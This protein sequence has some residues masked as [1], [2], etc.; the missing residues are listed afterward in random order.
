[1][2]K[3]YSIF[4]LMCSLCVAG[5]ASEAKQVASGLVKGSEPE[6]FGIPTV[7][8]ESANPA[9]TSSNY[10]RA[11]RTAPYVCYGAFVLLSIPVSGVTSNNLSAFTENNCG[12]SPDA[13]FLQ[14]TLYDEHN[15]SLNANSVFAGCASCR[16]FAFVGV[17]LQSLNSIYFSSPI[18]SHLNI[19]NY[20]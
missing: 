17:T 20:G 1:M 13:G 18:S 2:K 3:L 12:V 8:I 9:N 10:E 19:G 14:H 7:V 16:F 4:I 6:S 11:E 15:I 5:F